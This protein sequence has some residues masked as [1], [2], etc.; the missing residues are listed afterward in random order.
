MADDKKTVEVPL[1]DLR[2]MQEQMAEMDRI[3]AESDAKQAGLEELLSKGASTNE[4]PKLRE[5][6]NFE[7]KFRTVRLHKYPIAG[8]IT[9]L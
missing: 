4:E 2:A 1:S 3:I 9:N 7:P 6:R 8:D 5:K